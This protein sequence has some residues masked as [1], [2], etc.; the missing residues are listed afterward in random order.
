MPS[1]YAACDKRHTRNDFNLLRVT[2][3]S[4]GAASAGVGTRSFP[5]RATR[6]GVRRTALV[7]DG[8]Q[9]GIL[10]EGLVWEL[11]SP[12]TGFSI[13][14]APGT[15]GVSRTGLC[16]K[17]TKRLAK[18]MAWTLQKNIR[19]TPE[20][21]DRIENAARKRDVSAN[22]LVV[23]LAIEALDRREWPRTELEIQ[24]L[25]SSLFAAQAIA[26]DMIASG[27]EEELEEI[28]RNISKIA[29]ELSPDPIDDTSEGRSPE[30][31]EARRLVFRTD[32]C[33]E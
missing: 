19:V 17:R 2:A 29:P 11:C 6:M 32:A 12:R 1:A 28:R 30:V 33:P 16:P 3:S 8:Y 31:V 9:S 15:C 13:D 22:R 24:L 25:R 26:R 20:Q 7:D 23:E 10:A 18:P 4:H 14:A 5:R 21:W 27:R